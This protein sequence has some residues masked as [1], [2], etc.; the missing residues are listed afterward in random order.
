MK[1]R[2]AHATTPDDDKEKVIVFAPGCKLRAS[3]SMLSWLCTWDHVVNLT[4]CSDVSLSVFAYF[5]LRLRPEREESP[6]A[7]SSGEDV[8]G[9]GTGISHIHS[10]GAVT[11]TVEAP[12]ASFS[13]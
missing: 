12:R 4:N 9:E 11:W 6:L 5:N 3:Y 2:A 1:I 8:G 10:S 13:W 7:R